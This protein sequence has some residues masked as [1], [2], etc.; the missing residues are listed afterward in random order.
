MNFG[1]VGHSYDLSSRDAHV[2]QSVL[3]DMI[4]F[5]YI[6]WDLFICLYSCPKSIVGG[7]LVDIQ[8]SLKK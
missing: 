7:P 2:R 6:G 3:K 4:A 8:N 1:V 5:K